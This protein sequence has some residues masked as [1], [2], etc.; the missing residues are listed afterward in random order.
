MQY[1][2]SRILAQSFQMTHFPQRTK[3]VVRLMGRVTKSQVVK[4][5]PPSLRQKLLAGPGSH[6]IYGKWRSTE[7][8]EE[9]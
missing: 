1:I 8:S 9:T 2:F 4:M 5:Q 3:H 7:F 6:G